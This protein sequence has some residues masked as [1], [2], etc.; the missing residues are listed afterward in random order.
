MMPYEPGRVVLVRFPFTNLQSAKKRPA[1]VVSPASY[2]RRYGDLAV[3]ALTSQPQPEPFLALDHWQLAGL[4]GPTWIKPSL[5]C[6]HTSLI[7]RPIG[8]LASDDGVRVA[9][10]LALL[11][12][13]EFLPRA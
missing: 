6:I 2:A 4:L 5:F 12:A 8:T 11:V 1:V 10:A 9:Q 7:D 3:L 13:G